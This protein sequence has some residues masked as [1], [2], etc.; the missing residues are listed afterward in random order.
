LW[1]GFIKIFFPDA[2]IIHSKRN[3]KDIFLSNYKNNFVSIDMDW[4]YDPDDILKYFNFYFEYMRFWKKK[5]EDFIYDINYEDIVNNS[6]HEIRKLLNY[7]ELEWDENCLNHH[8]SKKT[9]IKTVSRYQARKP[10]YK[11]SIDSNKNY[12]QSLEKYFDQLNYK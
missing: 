8:K 7:C 9:M 2:K 3:Y 10:I 5:C 12:Q 4:S 6:E 11:T 1:F